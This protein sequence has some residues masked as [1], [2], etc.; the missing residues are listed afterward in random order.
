MATI[1]A[2]FVGVLCLA[3]IV[4]PIIFFQSRKVLR[5]QKNFERGLKMVPLLIHLPPPSDDTD[6]GNRDVR[7]VTDENISKAQI[8]YSVIASTFEKNFK[9][10]FYGQRHVSF[11]IL[12]HNGKI[13][14]FTAV[15]IG[16]V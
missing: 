9:R 7:D 15:P 8:L 1:I 10:Q 3:L 6:A 4:G 2:L 11:E 5:E 16:L 12:A 13:D 14:F